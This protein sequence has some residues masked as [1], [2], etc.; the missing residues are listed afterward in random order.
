VT[1]VRFR[2]L[3]IRQKLLLTTLLSTGAALALAGGGFL[4]WDIV[5][6]RAAVRQDVITQSAIV[7]ENSGAPL[8][9]G[10]NRVGAEILRTLEVW[11]RLDVAC[12]YTPAGDVFAS[13]SGSGG[14]VC[15]AP[16][17]P[18]S[19][20]GWQTFEVVAPVTVDRRAVGTL[21]IRRGLGDLYARLRV[22]AA[23]VLALLTFAAATAVLMGARMQRAIATPL[24][25]LADTAQTISRTHDY[26]LRAA[27]TS[28][29]EIGTVVRS[30]N[31]ML[32]RTAEALERERTANR[33]KDEFL[34]TLSHELRTPLN[35]VLGWTHI[36]RAPRVDAQA[37]A[38]A[39]G[40]IERNARA[41]ALL[42]EDLLDMASIARGKPRFDVADV[43]LAAIVE[44][45]IEVMT[46][47]AAAKRLRIDV[48]ISPRPAPTRGDAGRLQQIAWNLLSNAIKFTPEGGHIWV[49]LWLDD[50]YR[51]SVRDT[52][53]GID[54]DF[55]P[56]VFE[57]F[58]QADG[59]PTRLHGGLG[60]GLA[61]TKQL[62]ELHGGTIVAR[63]PGPGKG[64]L[65]EV[66]FP[67]VFTVRKEPAP[68]PPAASPRADVDESLL[69]G[70][71]VLV[72][73]DEEDARAILETTLTRHGAR[74]STAASVREAMAAIDQRSPD[75]LLSDIGMPHQDGYALLR[76]LRSRSSARGATTPAVAITAYAS[77]GDRAAAAAAGYEAHV[78]KPFE[79]SV[80]VNL[81]ARLG[82]QRHGSA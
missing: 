37:R 31:E 44:T 5:Q 17:P 57:P 50:G 60:L 75:V 69:E 64:A 29:D 34:A 24:L 54:A 45:A 26:S 47:S 66:H 80:V 82:R 78:A 46:P 65:F 51:L 61:I 16:P 74:V 7:A 39:L 77:A 49:R 9:F 38:R 43:D 62:V 20:F 15:P 14:Q 21:Y 2:H 48:D 59:S 32:D 12:L 1:V 63:S 8:A 55:L 53:A 22:G 52:G 76:E 41:Q 67:T 81:V 27:P 56:Q 40:A 13:Y 18:R 33:L 23:A 28:D 3:P 19:D 79:P 25:Q 30:F 72:V 11:P 6:F 73:D 36:L 68:S 42:V 10:D 71:H 58:R 4:A 70:L 35:A